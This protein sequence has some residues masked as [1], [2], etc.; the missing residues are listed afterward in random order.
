MQVQSINSGLYDNKVSKPSFQVNLKDVFTVIPNTKVCKNLT[1]L[2]R[3]I[4][5][6]YI[7]SRRYS[8]GVTPDEFAELKKLSGKDFIISSYELLTK[9]FGYPQ[10]IRPALFNMEISSDTP[11]AYSPLSNMIVVNKNIPDAIMENKMSLFSSMRHELMHYNQNMQILR[12]EEIGENALDLCSRKYL[13]NLRISL[14][15]LITQKTPQE[16]MNSG[17]LAT[18]QDQYLYM[19]GYNLYKS[20]NMSAFNEMVETAGRPYRSN[21]EDFRAKVI[22]TLG[23]IK[24]DS[25]LTEQIQKYLDDFLNVGY[26]NPDGKVDYSKYFRTFVEQEAMI[27]QGQAEFEYSGMGCFVK[28]AK[29][30]AKAMINSQE[31]TDFLNKIV[32]E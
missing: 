23:V 6:Q 5:Q 2:D 25:N 20:G 10:E 18:P 28:L 14:V 9:K 15:N 32:G 7:V 4:V 29:E 19:T 31:G 3:N 17:F 11:M 12:H 30:Q 26:Y 16:V 1:H 13:E 8:S 27:A 22:D 24:K 21:L